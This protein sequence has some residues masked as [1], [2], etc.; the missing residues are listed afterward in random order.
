MGVDRKRRLTHSLIRNLA[1]AF[2]FGTL[3]VIEEDKA[4]KLD[5]KREAKSRI[6]A[7]RLTA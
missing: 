1:R 6:G 5:R 3:R 7:R 4:E 2:G